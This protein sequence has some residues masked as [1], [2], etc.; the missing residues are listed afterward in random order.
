MAPRYPPEAPPASAT[1]PLFGR[2]AR[3]RMTNGSEMLPGVDGRTLWVRRLRDLVALHISDL[4]G[5]AACSE[6]EKSIVR[7]AATLT[8][9]LERLEQSFALAGQASV[10]ELELYS[11]LSNTLRRLLD[12]T[13]LQRRSR[14]ITP[15]LDQY[16]SGRAGE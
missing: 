16:I 4:G 12:V 13:G 9:E 10:E 1:K 3:S 11:R 8:V 15:T 2:T 6:A 14:D 7:R 5:E